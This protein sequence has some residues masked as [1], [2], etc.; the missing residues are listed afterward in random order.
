MLRPTPPRSMMILAMLLGACGGDG[1]RE[2]TF[3]PHGPTLDGADSLGT[4]DASASDDSGEPSP[5]DSDSGD[6]ATGEGNDDA[7]T[8]VDAG[9][10]GG[11]EVW[12]DVVA[13]VE[14]YVAAQGI[15]GA[16]IA[17]VCG[18][19][20]S[21]AAGIGVLREGSA[22][23]VAPTSRFQLASLTKMFTGAAAVSLSE[24]GVVDLQAPI[25][26]ILPTV[27]YGDITLHHLL[28]H[29]ASYPTEFAMFTSADLVTTV[30]DNGSQSMWAPPG[31]VWNYSN[32]GFSVAGAALERAAGISFG[33]LVE[34]RVFGP[35]NMSRA[36]M[37]VP[38][39]LADGDYA[40]G[41]SDGPSVSSPIAPD[42]SY[43]ESGS[44]GPMG[45]AWGSI[46]DLARWG[47]VHLQQGGQVL[48]TAGAALLTQFHT[49]TTSADQG[50]GYGHFVDAYLNPIVISH[51]GS[52][53]GFLSDWRIVPDLDFGVFVVINADWADPTV[54]GDLISD[55]YVEFG[56]QGGP[57][58]DA[59]P[60]DYVGTYVDPHEL[61][62]ISVTASG[63]EL[64]AVI[65][66]ESYPMTAWGDD[67]YSVYHPVVGDEIF[68]TFWPGAGTQM[69]YMVS[70]W[71]IATR[72]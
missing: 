4:E 3:P 46:E 62:T 42:G 12:D 53:P 66:G 35:A 64:T 31:A 27:G 39:V 59:L 43:F 25:S 54:I 34:T 38:V 21:H 17:V 23:L 36:T 28:T 56:Y 60:T 26:D 57:G 18:G 40:F 11:P 19:T 16:A 14:S 67:T 52:S 20:L 8:G 5:S 32:P 63:D 7:S 47:E 29:T 33:Q 30:L 22:E 50:Y 49:R 68:T 37:G 9:C 69:R 15:P 10:P 51:G 65:N 1:G 55:R 58:S 72:S 61:G 70:I 48:S 45:G 24:E 2:T 13:D 6:A 41:H 71:G 44:Y